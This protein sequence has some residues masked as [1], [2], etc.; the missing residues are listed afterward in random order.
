M[1]GHAD[2]SEYNWGLQVLNENSNNNNNNNDNNNSNNKSFR[3][4]VK[5]DKPKDWLKK[6]TS[7]K[8]GWG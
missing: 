6:T 1:D 4:Y 2:K 3:I 5:T 8:P 7:F